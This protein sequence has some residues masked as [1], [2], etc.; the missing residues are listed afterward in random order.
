MN[1]KWNLTKNRWKHMKTYFTVKTFTI[2]RLTIHSK[3]ADLFASYGAKKMSPFLK[4]VIRSLLFLLKLYL[5]NRLHNSK[6]E[7]I[8]ITAEKIYL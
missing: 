7:R 3:Y 1:E 4:N 2:K 5:I 8:Y 6:P